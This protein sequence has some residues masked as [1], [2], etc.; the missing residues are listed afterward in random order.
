[1]NS[2]HTSSFLI[3]CDGVAS[4]QLS[5][6]FQKQFTDI[7]FSVEKAEDGNRIDLSDPEILKVIIETTGELLGDILPPL[8]TFLFGRYKRNRKENKLPPNDDAEM[9]IKLNDGKPM[10]RLPAKGFPGNI[11]EDVKNTPLEDIEFI[12]IK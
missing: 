7:K 10:K 3:I 4:A 8:M 9:G 5:K 6:D 2:I 12:S 1:M 11:P